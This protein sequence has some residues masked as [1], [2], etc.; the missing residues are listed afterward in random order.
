[1]GGQVACRICGAP[2]PGSYIK[3]E[4]RAGRMG[5]APLA[6]IVLKPPKPGARRAQGREY[7]PVGA[8]ALPDD[9]LCAERLA[10]LDFAP[11]TES[12]PGTMRIT[13]GTCMVYGM[14]RYQD[15]FTPRQLL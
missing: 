3:M 8:Y 7:L 2:V 14:A 10:K 5:V 1:S 9:D 6:A 4:A 15:L 11:L 12:L 13:G